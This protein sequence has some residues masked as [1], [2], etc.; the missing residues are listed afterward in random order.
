MLAI[1]TSVFTESMMMSSAIIAE[2][3]QDEEKQKLNTKRARLLKYIFTQTDL[4]GTGRLTEVKWVAMLDDE[5]LHDEISHITGLNKEELRDSFRVVAAANSI[6][7]QNG[8]LELI[9]LEFGAF[10]TYLIHNKESVAKERS[11]LKMRSQL[12]TAVSQLQAANSKIELI[13]ARK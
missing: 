10:A 11:V 9:E 13:A 4:D 8:K 6:S 2:A 3:D 5:L 7:T 1:L 12:F